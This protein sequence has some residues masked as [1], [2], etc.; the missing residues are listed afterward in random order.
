MEGKLNTEIAD[1]TAV[2]SQQF[3]TL[4]ASY[5]LIDKLAIVIKG[6]KPEIDNQANKLRKASQSNEPLEK[7]TGV[8]ESLTNHVSSAEK[9]QMVALK[10]LKSV[11]LSSGESLQSEKGLDPNLRRQLRMV[12]NRLKTGVSTSTDLQPLL[13]SLLEIFTAVRSIKPSAENNQSSNKNIV[14]ILVQSLE[15]LSEQD[16]VIPNLHDHIV[17]IKGAGSE[18]EK[19]DLCLKSFYLII[20]QFSEEFKQTQKLVLNINSA[21]EEVHNA[22]VQSLKNSKSYDKELKVLNQK[23][24]KQIKELSQN[25]GE[26]KSIDQ[27][28]SLLD[29]KIQSITLSIRQ[30]EA[31]E[32]KRTEEL[33]STLTVMESKLAQL[34]ERTDFYRNKWLEE[35][36]RSE[37]DALTELPNRGAYDKRVEEEIQ[38]CSRN[39][40]PLCVAVLDIDFFKKINDKY[41]HSVGDKTLQIV[42][43]SLRKTFRATD[44]IARYGGEEFVCLLVNTHP[45]EAIQPLEKVRK[46]IESIPFVIKKDRLNITISIG[47]SE[48]RP[49]DDGHTLF[50]RADKALYEAKQTGRNKVC[51]N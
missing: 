34:E 9:E 20:E 8:I 48:L 36:S 44:Y 19:L 40:E 51:Y 38:R 32:D 11:M 4:T 16:N 18:T 21:L 41:G 39:S 45:K 26:A 28:Q 14:K 42:A 2:N 17:K 1:L 35:K 7:I 5:K 22:L 27:L 33:N 30:R 29:T 13:V 15:K 43:K 3:K 47:V 23:I 46:A 49:T 12:V 25:A 37:T 6:T 24:N 31:I 10:E 50:D